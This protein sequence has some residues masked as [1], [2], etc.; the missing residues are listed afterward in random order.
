MKSAIHENIS[1]DLAQFCRISV[2]AINM[3]QERDPDP[4]PKRGF[5]DLVKERI[6]ESP[7]VAGVGVQWCNLGSLQPLPPKFK[8]GF[9]LLSRVE[10]SGAIIAHCHL[11]HP[12]SSDPPMSASQVAGTTVTH[13]YAQ[14]I[15]YSFVEKGSCYVAQAG[16]QLL[17]LSDTC[18]PSSWDYRCLPPCLANFCTF[19]RDRVLPCCP[20]WSQTPGLKRSAHLNLP[21][22]WDYSRTSWKI[23]ANPLKLYCCFIN[24]NSSS[25]NA[26][27]KGVVSRIYKKLKQ[28]QQVKT[29]NPIE[30]VSLSCSGWSVMVQSWLTTASASWAQAI[31]PPQSPELS[32]AL[33]PRLECNGEILAHCNIYLLGSRDSCASASQVAGITAS[34]SGLKRTSPLRLLSSWDE[35]H[36][37]SHPANFCIFCRYEVLPCCLDWPRTPE[38]K[39]SSHL[40][41]LKAGECGNVIVGELLIANS[42][43]LIVVYLFHILKI[44]LG[45]F[46]FISLLWPRLECNGT[47]S[48]HCNL[49]LLGFSDSPASAS[50]GLALLPRLEC[51]GVIIA[52]SAL[53][54]LAQ[55]VFPL[56]P[57]EY[58]SPP[59][60][61]TTTLSN[62][63][64]LFV[65]IEFCSCCPGWGMQ[66]HNLG[67]LQL[68]PPGFKRFS[69]LSLLSSWDYRHLPPHPAAF[70]IF[71]S[72]GGVSLLARLVSNFQPRDLPT[73]AS[74]S[75]GIIG[76][77]HCSCPKRSTFLYMFKPFFC[78]SLPSSW[79]YTHTSPHSAFTF[80]VETRFPHVDQAGL[81]LLT[82]SDLPASASQSAGIT[83]VNHQAQPD[84][85]FCVALNA[86]KSPPFVSRSVF[87]H[88]ASLPRAPQQ[89]LA[90]DCF[91]PLV[92]SVPS[93]NMNLLF[94][95]TKTQEV[96][97]PSHRRGFS[98]R[99]EADPCGPPLH[100]GS[101][102]AMRGS[103]HHCHRLC[104]QRRKD[105]ETRS[106]SVTQAGVQWHNHSSLQPQ[107]PGLKGR[108]SLGCE[109]GLELLASTNTPASRPPKV[110]KLQALE[111]GSTILADYNLCLPGSRD[112]PASASQVAGTRGTI[113]IIN[114]TNITTTAITIT[115]TITTIIIITI[116]TTITTTII[117]ITTTTITTIT[118]TTTITITT[119]ITTITITTVTTTITI[120]T[121]ST[122]TPTTITTIITITITTTTIPVSPPFHNQTTGTSTIIITIST[123][124]TITTTITTTTTTM[125]FVQATPISPKICSSRCDTVA[126]SKPCQ[127]TSEDEQE[128]PS[129]APA[130]SSCP[131]L[132]SL[133]L[134]ILAEAHLLV[135]GTPAKGLALSPRLECSGVISA[136]H[137]L[138]LSG[139]SDSHA[140]A[141]QVAGI[142]GICH[143]A[144]LIFVFL[145]DMGFCH[146]G[147]TGLEPTGLNLHKQ[148]KTKSL[149]NSPEDHSTGPQ[150][151]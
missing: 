25:T 73:S 28:F 93:T 65:E 88:I 45:P 122:I 6:Q 137:N 57:L 44:F 62:F 36:T 134:P 141:S 7:T 53:N 140:S 100:A 79:N 31:L 40:S 99:M 56:Q 120:T 146:V 37:S 96:V 59:Q 17:G 104:V 27:N 15:F 46:Y 14:I 117:T 149:R 74:Q 80:L 150:D 72:R 107:P 58:T 89:A 21:M 29:N 47:I 26:S 64:D 132:P 112:S 66:W 1:Y 23:G 63:F 139:S 147:Q 3:L 76:M 138:R 130:F 51:G 54:S 125:T 136:H 92:L 82:S 103:Y 115:T 118:T 95:I 67:S 39:Q 13:H 10:C 2:V 142:T 50:R 4:D 110:L 18:L 111:C 12:S 127:S 38:L 128:A 70:C 94:S 41:L 35:K 9:T 98:S 60:P 86:Q 102:T 52:H 126:P 61:Y 69:C 48:A 148:R 109:A 30:K 121:R 75:A 49:C 68:L 144:W 90:D 19:S 129:L 22:C 71:F 145:A 123:T 87:H 42:I 108:F 135:G 33:S 8:Q 91:C 106:C 83:G 114:T 32:L 113:I 151:H 124:T 133:P 81:E 143:H 11:C 16:L 97:T 55:V 85:S 24:S 119:T 105:R 78:L 20:G 116:T 131:L 5:L 43:S 84:S 34:N 77:S 101:S